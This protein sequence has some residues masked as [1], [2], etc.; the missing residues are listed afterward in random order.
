LGRS[1]SRE[2]GNP[3]IGHF[4]RGCRQDACTTK[5]NN[6]VVQASSLQRFPFSRELR[7]IGSD[8]MLNLG[9]LMVDLKGRG[10]L[11][12]VAQPYFTSLIRTT[13]VGIPKLQ[14]SSQLWKGGNS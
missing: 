11:S 13:M 9:N 10:L 8:R 6:L 2:S 4:A 12:S 1:H 3:E 5:H 7:N 14:Y